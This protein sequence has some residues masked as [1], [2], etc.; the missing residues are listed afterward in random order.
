[1]DNLTMW[2][3]KMIIEHGDHSPAIIIN[4]DAQN[5]EDVVNEY[6][7]QENILKIDLK[8]F[9]DEDKV[10]KNYLINKYGKMKDDVELF[11]FLIRAIADTYL[12]KSPVLIY[13]IEK[14]PIHFSGDKVYEEVFNRTLNRQTAYIYSVTSNLFPYRNDLCDYNSNTFM[15]MISNELEKKLQMNSDYTIFTG[16]GAEFNYWNDFNQYFMHYDLSDD[17]DKVLFLEN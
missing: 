8:A 15:V 10:I 5:Q 12:K 1:M 7:N 14:L 9:F 13:N 2:K 16:T 11:S 17:K 4:L 3:I 6:F